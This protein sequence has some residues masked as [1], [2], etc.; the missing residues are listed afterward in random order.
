MKG[1]FAGDIGLAEQGVT[2][3][4]YRCRAVGQVLDGNHVHVSLLLAAAADNLVI[5]PK[6]TQRNTPHVNQT[7]ERKQQDNGQAE[8]DVQ[9]E[10]Q[11]CA[12]QVTGRIAVEEHD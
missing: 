3:P 5:T 11:R 6:V 10:D 2:N 7:G 4:N 8:E 9:F 12:D 1:C